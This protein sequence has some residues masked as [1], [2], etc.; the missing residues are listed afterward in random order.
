MQKQRAPRNR[1]LTVND[2]EKPSLRQHLFTP[3]QP[4]TVA[5]VTDRT[6]WGDL[7]QVLEFLP[8]EFANLII[9][10]PPYNL[11][12]DF[13]GN[14][15]T[16]LSES[17][18]LDYLQS[19]FPRVVECLKSGGSLYL[20]GDWK[21]TSALQTVMQEHLT[22][23]N[24]IT[25]QREKGRGAKTN[26]KNSMEDIWFGVKDAN[27]YTFNV[28]AVKVK[29]KVLAP[30]RHEG[31]PKDWQ[32]TEEG[33]FRLTHPSN[34]WDDITVPYWSMPENTDHPTQ[35]PEKL[36]AKLILASSN[37]GDIV[38]DPFLGSGTTSVVARKLNR[39][40]C[41]V[42]MNED[43]CLLAEKRLQMAQTDKTIQGYVD[44]V[45]WERN[46]LK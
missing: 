38:F 41:G 12:K 21:C 32:E 26:W 14:K 34:F 10:D 29:R 24:R 15:F 3:E 17:R 1:T 18:Y 20:C 25:W 43:Y 23:L 35:K 22:V 39:R 28:D 36:I 19:W 46:T 42:E 13:A 27:Q 31:K 40:F 7:M 11:T 33:K 37:E 6:I 5:Q 8:R 30:Y 2:D 45:F 9:I 16:Q 4:V 44:G